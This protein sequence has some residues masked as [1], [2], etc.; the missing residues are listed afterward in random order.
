[1]KYR[2]LGNTGVTVS[3]VGLGTHQFS[4]EW[5]KEFDVAEVRSL[6]W[7]AREL[8][9]NLLDTAEC[10]GDHQVEALIGQSISANRPEW[11]IATKF[12]HAYSAGPEKVE[13]WSAA[14]VQRQLEAS[15]RALKTEC[16][17]LYQFHS[18]SNDVFHNDE[19]WAMLNAQV[20]AGKIRFLGLSLSAAVVQRHDTSQISRADSVGVRVIQALYNRLHAEAEQEV[21]PFCERQGFGLLARVPLA[22]GFLAGAYQPGAVFAPNDTRAQFGRE[23]NDQQLKR[24]QE[25]KEREVPP[26]QNMAQWALAWCLRKPAVSAVIVGCKSPGQLELNAAAAALV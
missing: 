26:G 10:Y 3:V 20:R 1:M 21:I 5:G 18:G 12:G 7:R 22:K 16:I 9:I 17:D 23:F 2:P 8:G 15:L 24:V 25:I 13:A 14:E 4:G 11:F 6:L 19:L